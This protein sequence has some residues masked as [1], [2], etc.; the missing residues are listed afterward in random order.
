MAYKYLGEKYCVMAGWSDA[1]HLSQ[2]ARDSLIQSIPKWQRDAREK[3]IPQLGEGAVFQLSESEYVIPVLKKGVPAHWPRSYALDVGVRITAAVWIAR[4][5]DTGIHYVYQEYSRE[6]APYSIHA[7]AIKDRGEWISGVVDP[8]A[9]QRNQ[10]DGERMIDNYR[11][12]GLKLVEAE[13][14]VNSGLEDLLDALISG[15]LKIFETCTV[16]IRQMRLYRRVKSKTGDQ[17]KILKKDDHCVDC[18]RYAWVSGR[19]VMKVR[20]KVTAVRA[21]QFANSGRAWMA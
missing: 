17:V 6:D 1:V 18:L 21:P 11:R 19:D 15:K 13:N 3:G 20:P 7:A 4:D 16:L 12:A 10:V 5:P 2:E 14:S 8:A 9:D